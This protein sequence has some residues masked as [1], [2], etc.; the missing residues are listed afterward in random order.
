VPIEVV[1]RRQDE[2]VESPPTP[3]PDGQTFPGLLWTAWRGAIWERVSDE[4]RVAELQPE[5]DGTLLVGTMCFLRRHHNMMA[6]VSG[7]AL[8]DDCGWWVD[9]PE[10]DDDPEAG[11]TGG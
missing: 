5:R 1:V 4:W 8:C 9:S 11:T 3:P 10:D 7:H 2:A 6:V